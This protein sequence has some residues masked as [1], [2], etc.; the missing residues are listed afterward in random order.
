MNFVNRF[1]PPISTLAVLT[2]VCLSAVQSLAQQQPTTPQTEDVLRINT[3]LVQTGV[4]VLDSRGNFVNGLKRE[5]FELVVDGKPQTISFF[6]QVETGSN[7][8]RQVAV[9]NREMKDQPTGKTSSAGDSYGRT[10]I[11]FIDD[12][13]L[14]LDSLGRTQKMLARFIDHEMVETDHVAIASPSG[15]I[16]FLQQFTDN[17]TVLRAAAARL[18]QKP[19]K[20]RDMSRETTP[21][22]EYMALTI[23]RKDDPGV[24]QFYVDECLKAAPPRYPRRSC[25]VEVINRARLILLQAASVIVNT[26]SSLERLMQSSAMFPSRKLAF[27]ISDGF[28]LE[29]GPRNADP[30]NALSRIIDEAMRAGVV[31]YSIDAR[32]LISG[33]LDATNNVPVDMQGRLEHALVREIPASQDA[34]NALARDTGGRALRNQNYFDQWVGKILDETSNYYLLAWRPDQDEGA[35]PHFKNITVRVISHPEYNVRLPRGF[36]SKKAAPAPAPAPAKTPPVIAAAPA[37]PHRELQEALTSLNPRRDI[38][39]SLSAIFMDTP[40]HGPVLTSSVRV[41]NDWLSYESIKGRPAAAVDVVGV[42]VNDRGK[43]VGSFQTRLNIDADSE[44][45][46]SSGTIYNSRLPLHPGLYQVRVAA[47]DANSGQTGSAQQWIEIPD[48]KSPRLS[49]S[50]LLLN[51]QNVAASSNSGIPQVQFSVDHRFAR[52]S[53]LTFMAFIYNAIRAEKSQPSLWIQARLWRRGRVVQTEPPRKVEFGSQDLVRISCGGEISL[54][55]IPPG[56]YVLEVA[57]TDAIN[58]T[59]TSQRTRITIDQAALR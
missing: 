45:Q 15:D 8:E 57:V 22:S 9:P 40:E 13:H 31:V 34:M 52:N 17:K 33:Q 44:N 55:S 2:L 12:L 14:S 16:G 6:E 50:S 43:P 47:R 37:Q 26:Y 38:P 19:Y 42:V 58:Q 35:L 24:F 49:M 4:T 36:L 30:R 18:T 27:F 46:K 25:E 56:D 3:E 51:V 23:E 28:L 41:A 7:R 59:S 32:G 11:F 48:L 1:P 5:Q 53:R 20:V 54:N 10:I 21:M 29:T 39:V